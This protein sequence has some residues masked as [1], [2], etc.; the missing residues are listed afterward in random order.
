LHEAS[1]GR[2]TELTARPLINLF[3]PLLSGLIQPLSGEYAGRRT[4]LEQLPFSTGY[5]VEIGLLIDI[6]EQ[7]GLNAIAQVDLEERIHRNQSLAALSRMS[8]TI[9]QTV[10]KRLESR[11]HIELVAEV[12]RSM[13]AIVQTS[14]HLQLDVR[15]VEE[16]ERPPMASLLAAA[17]AEQP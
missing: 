13:K 11:R 6:L 12:N 5:G 10:I 16:F 14:D 15:R 7:F 4:L 3:Y 9:M 2:V 17:S 1:G 8:F